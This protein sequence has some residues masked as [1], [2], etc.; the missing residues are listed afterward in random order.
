MK[1]LVPIGRLL[2]ASLFILSGISHFAQLEAVTNAA[3]AAGLPGA[4][5]AVILS[6]AV[7]LIGGLCVL[8]G[9]F[10]RT[11]A[12]L[13]AAFLLVSAIVMHAFW[14]APDPMMAQVQLG[15]FLRNLSLA[16]GALLIVYFGPGPYSLRRRRRVTTEEVE[17]TFEPPLQPRPQE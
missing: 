17:V 13:L 15:N 14:R 11:G 16:G 9:A 6:G 2:F 4:R 1:A 8:T 3:R 5:W 10:A 7:L 12:A